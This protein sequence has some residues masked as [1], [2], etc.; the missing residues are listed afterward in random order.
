MEIIRIEIPNYVRKIQLSKKQRPR[1]FEW[2]GVT[3]KAK[4]YVVPR[5]FFKDKNNY[6][7]NITIEDLKDEYILAI[8][9]KKSY[10]DIKTT[11]MVRTDNKAFL[12]TEIN[13]IITPILANVHKAYTPKMYL[14]N[15]QDIYNNVLNEFTRGKV[16]D[17]I[18][19]CYFP[20]VKD[21]PVITEYPIEINCEIHDTI[22]N[23]YT[24]NK[25][26]IGHRWDVDNLAFPYV[27]AFPDLL[28][29]LGKIVDDDRLHLPS[30]IKA[31]F[32]PI[33][34]HNNRKLVFIIS[35][36]TRKEIT[37]NEVYKS[38]HKNKETYET[39]DLDLINKEDEE[40]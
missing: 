13:G 14:I 31:D 28:T 30:S 34:D 21:I 11:L 7:E 8:K 18:K 27:K 17:E 35:K 36:V 5:R 29:K 20:Y 15:G 24:N 10:Q 38:Y 19:A 23:F 26:E 40:I 37:E 1:Y 39:E 32:I 33:E 16:M 4:G 2:N 6:P 3:I 25:D 22:K 9:G 12:C